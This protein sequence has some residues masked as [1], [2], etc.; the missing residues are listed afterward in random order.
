MIVKKISIEVY[1]CH[2]CGKQWLQRPR[3]T[4][5]G[6][7]KAITKIVLDRPK[8][9]SECKSRYWEKGIAQ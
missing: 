5:T 8:N 2:Q 4:R 3:P 9:C 6:D 7:G 1:E